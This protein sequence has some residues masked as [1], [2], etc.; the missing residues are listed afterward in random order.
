MKRIHRSVFAVILCMLLCFPVLRIKADSERDEQDG[1]IIFYIEEKSGNKAERSFDNG[2]RLPVANVRYDVFAYK[3]GGPNSTESPNLAMGIK[4]IAGDNENPDGGGKMRYVYCMQFEKSSPENGIIMEERGW[5]D[6]KVAYALYY[7]AVYYGFPCRRSEYSTG[8]WKMDYFVTQVAVHVL[9]GEFTLDAVV[10]GMN[11]SAATEAEKA[12]AYD[13][14]V[15]LVNAASDPANYGGFSEEGWMDMNTASFTLNGYQDSWYYNEGSYL[16]A[17]AFHP[18]FQSYNGYDFREQL[19]GYEVMVPEGVSV[20][21]QET[22]LYADFHLAVEETRY[23]Q[24]QLTGKTIPVTVKASIPRYWGGCVYQSIS[25]PNYQNVCLLRWTPIGGTSV[26]ER[27]VELHIPKVTQNLTVYKRDVETG[28]ALAGADFSLWA[29]DGK[30]YSKKVGTFTD[31]KDGSYICKGVDYTTATDGWFL[32]KEESAPKTYDKNYQKENSSDEEDFNLYGGREIRMNENGFW[33]DK[34]SEPF[35]FRDKKLI[36]KA[37]LSVMKYNIDNGEN[38]EGAEFSIFEW[39]GGT[40]Q[41]HENPVQVLKYNQTEQRYETETSLVKNGSNGGKFLVKETKVPKGYH[42]P[43]SQEIVLTEP[44]TV[45]LELQAP[46][47]PG[48]TLTIHKKILKEEVVWDHGNP[49]FFFKITGSD[50]EGKKHTYHCFL[51]F[52]PGSA[53]GQEGNYLTGQTVVSDIPAGTYQIREIE[54]VLRYVLTDAASDQ[55]N[56]T[57]EK[58]EAGTV[59]GVKRIQAKVTADLRLRNGSVTFENRKVRYDEY[60]DNAVVTNHFARE[61]D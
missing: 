43:W 26:F 30:A 61:A 22:P 31:Q 45:K 14:I 53:E 40:G 25:D 11:K 6:K 1:E 16:S 18:E 21:K 59:N 10:N 51:E 2:S 17:G 54:D 49:T 19:T 34:V 28:R 13:R 7:G 58:T 35:V 56:V 27:K 36:P 24:W 48:R 4:Y 23:R 9:N 60:S 5:A 47:Y 20:Q 3:V 46:N 8:D 38:I 32:I 57:V 33:S 42:C 12:L 44:G 52:T 29:Y 50:L 41:Y 15:K 37:D 39:N 55:E